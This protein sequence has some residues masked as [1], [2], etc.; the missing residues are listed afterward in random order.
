MRNR[1][2]RVCSPLGWGKT[3]QMFDDALTGGRP[4]SGALIHTLAKKRKRLEPGCGSVPCL[5]DG[6]GPIARAGAGTTATPKGG[7]GGF[8]VCVWPRC[9]PN[10]G[11]FFTI[12]RRC[13]EYRCPV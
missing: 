2:T 1:R 9:V 8:R 6:R 5:G 13:R 10:K 7:Q 3:T 12:H 11:K 4:T